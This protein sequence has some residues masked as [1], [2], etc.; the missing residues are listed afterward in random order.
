MTSHREMH[1]KTIKAVS[2]P[3]GWIVDLW[4]NLRQLIC[5]ENKEANTNEKEQYE[6]RKRILQR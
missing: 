4:S 6:I 2:V 1:N 3:G 5:Y